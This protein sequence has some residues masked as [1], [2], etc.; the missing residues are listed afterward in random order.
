MVRGGRPGRGRYDV[1]DGTRG[2]MVHG[3]VGVGDIEGTISALT[4]ALVSGL[5]DGQEAASYV[6]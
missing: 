1:G 2:S 5:V 3:E 6:E 4:C